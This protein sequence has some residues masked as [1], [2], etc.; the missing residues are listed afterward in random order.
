MARLGDA[1]TQLGREGIGC[2]AADRVPVRRPVLLSP[3][4]G[5][6][7]RRV[8]PRHPPDAHVPTWTRNSRMLSPMTWEIFLIFRDD[9]RAAHVRCRHPTRS[10]GGADRSEA[11]ALVVVLH[12]GLGLPLAHLVTLLFAIDSASRDSRA[13]VL[14]CARIAARAAP[15]YYAL[16][17]SARQ[18]RRDRLEGRERAPPAVGCATSHTSVSNSAWPWVCR[19]APILGKGF[20]GAL[21]RDVWAQYRGFAHADHEGVWRISLSAVDCCRSIILGVGRHQTLEASALFSFRAPIRPSTPPPGAP[22]TRTVRQL[23]CAKSAG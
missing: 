5:H 20:A 1:V 9:V 7:R 17:R 3:S 4:A 12:K 2:R 22:S 15:S 23:C 21:A 16:V 6:C 18:P 19:R 10:A 8:R 14:V 13:L 11:A